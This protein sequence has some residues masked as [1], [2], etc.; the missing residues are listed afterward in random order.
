MN[1]PIYHLAKLAIGD[2]LNIVSIPGKLPICSGAV[3]ETGFSLLIV[4]EE[5]ELT[6]SRSH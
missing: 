2:P 3:C 5:H 6:G 4:K 1:K